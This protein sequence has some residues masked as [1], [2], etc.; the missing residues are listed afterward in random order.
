M[1]RTLFIGRAGSGAAWYRIV[2]P[3]TFLGAHWVGVNADGQSMQMVSGCLSGAFTADTP[4]QY[5]TVVLQSP[6]GPEWLAYVERLRAAG[7]RVLFDIDDD[8]WAIGELDDHDM[9]AHFDTAA[10]SGLAMVAEAADGVICSTEPIAERMRSHNDAVWICRNGLDLSRYALTR[11]AHDGVVVGW[12]GATGHRRA[13]EPW[14]SSVDSVLASRADVRFVSVGQDFA[15]QLA[16]RH[17]ADRARAIPFSAIES[18]PAAM[19]QFDVALAPAAP[20]GFHRAK[21]DLRWLEAAALGIPVV[22][23]PVVYPDIEHGVTGLHA[24]TPAEAHEALIALIGDPALRA[25]IGDAGREHVRAHRA[26]PVMAPQWHAPLAG[27]AAAETE[28]AEL[29]R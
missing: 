25:R 10:L 6:R 28:L 22:A 20:T 18:Y 9:A 7:V 12:A 19:T 17:G 16:A 8:P 26:M 11:P 4:F 29:A 14:L 13:I 27:T 5:E 21:S 24:S 23:D 1:T 15:Q 3:A 2:L